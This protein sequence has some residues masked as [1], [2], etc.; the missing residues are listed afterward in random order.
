[1][2]KLKQELLILTVDGTVFRGIRIELQQNPIEDLFPED[3]DAIPL[4]LT[5][6]AGPY[7]VNTT[8]FIQQSLIVAVSL[9]KDC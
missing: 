9:V 4:L 2:L 5:E 6:D 3:F 7:E 1:M 8:V